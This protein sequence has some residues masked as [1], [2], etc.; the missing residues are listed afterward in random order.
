LDRIRDLVVSDLELGVGEFEVDA[1]EEQF[2]D[3]SHHEEAHLVVAGA[4]GVLE[5]E[6]QIDALIVDVGVR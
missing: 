6:Q 3:L 4:P 2:L 5:R 1:S